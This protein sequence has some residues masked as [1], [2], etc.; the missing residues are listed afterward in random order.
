L[1]RLDNVVAM[2]D[3]SGS[4]VDVMH[5]LDQCKNA[6]QDFSF[7]T[8]REEIFMACLAAGVGGCLTATSGILPEIM[9]GIYRAWRAG[10]L[11][12]ARQL[13]FTILGLVRTVFAPPFPLG[14]KAA[15]ATRGFCDGSACPAPVRAQESSYSIV[16]A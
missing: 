4:M 1:A 10:D 9:V 16:K 2:K 15:M 3:S 8:G 6:G 14:F 12:Q 11:D 5:F 7:L 13:Q